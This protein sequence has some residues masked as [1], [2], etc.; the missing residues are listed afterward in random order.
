MSVTVWTKT[1][2]I[3]VVGKLV[4]GG[5]E[6]AIKAL[7]MQADLD[8]EELKASIEGELTEEAICDAAEKLLAAKGRM[9]RFDE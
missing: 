7:A 6:W 4:Q 2:I 5:M 3:F 1:S 9:V 8:A